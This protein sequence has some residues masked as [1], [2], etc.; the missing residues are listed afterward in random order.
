MVVKVCRC[1]CSMLLHMQL[2]MWQTSTYVASQTYAAQCIKRPNMA[3]AVQSRGH[4][5]ICGRI[6]HFFK[7]DGMQVICGQ[8]RKNGGQEKQIS[9]SKSDQ[10][11]LMH[12]RSFFKVVEWKIVDSEFYI[13]HYTLANFPARNGKEWNAQQ[14]LMTLRMLQSFQ[15]VKMEL[16]GLDWV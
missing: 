11:N 2:H 9:Y 14:R 5:C 10:R 1:I 13:L 16:L 4:L 8:L 15:K 6:N 12:L 3:Y 7:N